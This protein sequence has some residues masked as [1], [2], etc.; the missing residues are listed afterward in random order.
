M[1]KFWDTSEDNL[2]KITLLSSFALYL[3]SHKGHNEKTWKIEILHAHIFVCVNVCLRARQISCY[4][5]HAKIPFVCTSTQSVHVRVVFMNAQNSQFTLNIYLSSSFTYFIECYIILFTSLY[6]AD[7]QII[8]SYIHNKGK[9]NSLR[10][11][12]E[13][14]AASS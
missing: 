10:T 14:W 11:C 5:V 7:I 12:Y 8:Y 13:N 2:F 9:V 1:D 6:F 3:W 4:S